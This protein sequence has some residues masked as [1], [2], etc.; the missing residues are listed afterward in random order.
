[1]GN[2]SFDFSCVSFLSNPNFQEPDRNLKLQYRTS[3]SS[4]FQEDLVEKP[5]YMP[6][7]KKKN[8]VIRN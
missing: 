2:N 7:A 4:S 3:V 6:M 5:S 8:L 1:M